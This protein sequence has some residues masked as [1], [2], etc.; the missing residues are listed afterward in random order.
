MIEL[1][2]LCSILALVV[3][4]GAAQAAPL[5]DRGNGMIYDPDRDLT[6]LADWN[7]AQTSGFD[8]NGR[9]NWT[10]ANGW[11]NDLVFGGFSDWRLPTA[12]NA[13]GTGPCSGFDCTGSELGNMFYDHF[14]GNQFESV[15]DQTGDTQEEMDNLAL[16]TNVQSSVYW[17][18]TEVAPGFLPWA[19]LPGGGGQGAD[20]E[21]NRWFAVAVRSGDVAAIPEPQTYAML[22]A[23][24]GLLAAMRIRRTK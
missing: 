23:G 17:S 7:Y 5:I 2:K 22:L 8:A 12:L 21:T 20:V 14:G 15:L 19:F 6:W 4:A 11:A 16:F 24:L 1:K 10:T 18:G 3:G 9:M 13:D